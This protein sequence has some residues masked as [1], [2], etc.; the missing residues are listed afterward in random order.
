MSDG[1][2]VMPDGTAFGFWDDATDYTRVYHVAC[3]CPDASDDNPGTEERPFAT[4][5]RAAEVLEPGEKVVVH[6]G[7]YRGWVRPARGGEGPERMIAYEAAPGEE[8]HV[9]GSAVW[10]PQF[11]PSEGWKVNPP[12]GVTVWMGDLPRELFVGYNPFMT[13]NMSSE[14]TTFTRDWSAEETQRFQI[15]RGMVFADGR[16]LRQVFRAAELGETD[17]AFWVEDPG[18]R[19]HLRLWDGADPNS[20]TFEVTVHEQVFAPVERY[21]GYIRVS[22]FHFAHAAD[23]VPIPQRAAVSANR[24]HHWIIED[25]TIRNINACGIDLG[26]QDWHAT[27]HEVRGGHIVRRNHLADI[28]ICGMAGMSCVDNALVE[29]NIIERVGGHNV[30]RIW[31]CGGLKFHLAHGVLIRRNV[32][33]HIHHAPGL[34]L[35]VLNRNCRISGNVFADIVS[36]QGGVYLECCHD[37]NL[38]DGNVFWD[39]RAEP[40]RRGPDNNGLRGGLG[41]SADSGENAVIAHNLF[42]KLPDGYAVG[43]HLNQKARLVDGRVGLC[44]GHKVLNNVFYQCPRR[45]LF[46]R[47]PHNAADGNLF[48]A[49][50]DSASLCI[51]YPEP[52]AVLNFAA[53]RDHHGFGAHSTQ[54]EIK[55]GF[56]P[57][58]LTLT[59]KVD[60]DIPACGPVDELHEKGPPRPPGPFATQHLDTMKASKQATVRMAKP[61]SLARGGSKRAM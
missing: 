20:V 5:Q 32:F 22:G 59:C 15:R 6:E 27:Q 45:I 25:C 10:S 16:P 28:G 21:L 2:A 53:W 55:A 41:V 47:A 46:S 52:A 43:C 49:S 3:G 17:G 31:E 56:D 40:S 33:R 60:G 51:Q 9:R 39:I 11:R 14:Y 7:I 24:G 8:V 58:E 48:D 57:E 37:T 38:V 4:I 30:E 42:G 34:W 13:V 23:G 61:E 19:L 26:A 54:A 12:D 1:Q 36:Y 29:D 35:D 50:N 18:L 44:R